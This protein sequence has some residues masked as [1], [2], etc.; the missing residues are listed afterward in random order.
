MNPHLP[1]SLQPVLRAYLD[2]FARDCPGLLSACYVHGS[3][4]L[5]AYDPHQSDVDCLVVLSR[6]CTAKDVQALDRI[7]TAMA[8]QYPGVRLECSYLQWAELGQADTEIAP[9]PVYH[10][11]RL[12]PLGKLDSNPVTW[13]LLK[14]C[15]IVVYGPDTLDYEIAW[16]DVTGWMRQNLNSYW[17]S[18]TTDPRR[19]LWLLSDSG[20]QWAVLGV[21]RQYY[22]FVEADI[23]S[24]LGA[25]DYALTHLPARW[26]SPDPGGLEH[27]ARHGRVTVSPALAAR[28]R[29][30]ALPALRDWHLQPHGLSAPESLRFHPSLNPLPEFKAGLQKTVQWGF[31]LPPNSG[32]GVLLCS[33]A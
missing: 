24:K 16:D 26:Q 17:R 1:D 21:L 12:Q 18:F 28:H 15:G 2:A 33:K 29:G 5:G 19:M 6:R 14:T 31:S 32:I 22:S 8:Q 13:W 23:T 10:E 20:L 9:S 4:A 7:H 11:G 30:A 27:P 3:V 25:G